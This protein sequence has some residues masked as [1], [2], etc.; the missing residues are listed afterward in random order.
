MKLIENEIRLNGWPAAD[1]PFSIDWITMRQW[2][3]LKILNVGSAS[4]VTN[5][6]THEWDSWGER[7]KEW[8]RE[9]KRIRTPRMSTDTDTMRFVKRKAFDCHRRC[10]SH[11]IK[12]IC[13]CV[14]TNELIS[15]ISVEMK[16]WFQNMMWHINNYFSLCSSSSWMPLHLMAIQMKTI[17]TLYCIFYKMKLPSHTNNGRLKIWA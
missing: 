10:R 3:K 12:I 13:V 5:E 2:C 11:T 7:A 16:K 17:R 6:W 9:K 4:D 14:C 15:S 8:V 1:L